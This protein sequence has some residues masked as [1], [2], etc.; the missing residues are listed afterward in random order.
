V[1]LHGAGELG[2]LLNMTEVTVPLQLRI[3]VRC[4]RRIQVFLI[5]SN[6]LGKRWICDKFAQ[7]GITLR[8][9]D[10]MFGPKR[11]WGARNLATSSQVAFERA[12]KLIAFARALQTATSTNDLSD[13]REIWD[14]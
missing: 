14:E 7:L 8:R 10:G 4:A 13:M 5:P 12:T 6:A 3:Q 11:W 2:V 9:Q 1:K